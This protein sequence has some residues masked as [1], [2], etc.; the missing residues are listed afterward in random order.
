MGV[1]EKKVADH[2]NHPLL[3]HPLGESSLTT[4]SFLGFFCRHV[5]RHRLWFTHTAYK[6]SDFDWISIITSITETGYMAMIN[7]GLRQDQIAS[8][9]T[10]EHLT[11][12]SYPSAWKVTYLKLPLFSTTHFVVPWFQAHI[13]NELWLASVT[14]AH[15]LNESRTHNLLTTSVRKTFVEG[16]ERPIRLRHGF[17]QISLR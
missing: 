14:F 2:P 12:R 8:L 7:V 16:N 15:T 3:N 5:C 9:Q 13:G 11:N 1:A 6:I 10:L 17:W 4:L